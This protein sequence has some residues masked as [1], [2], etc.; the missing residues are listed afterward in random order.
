[1]QFWLGPVLTARVPKDAYP[2]LPVRYVTYIYTTDILGN[3]H[4]P[5]VVEPKVAVAI[6]A[7]GRPQRHVSR[8]DGEIAGGDGGAVRTDGPAETD[9]RFQ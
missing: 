4:L 6:L 1:V 5:A 3:A 2:H 8:W 9:K 7:R